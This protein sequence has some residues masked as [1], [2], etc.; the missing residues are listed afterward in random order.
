MSATL[1][2][3][4]VLVRE[5][6]CSIDSAQTPIIPPKDKGLGERMVV[7]PSLVNATLGRNWVMGICRQL[8]EKMKYRVVVLSPSES[9]ARE[10]QIFGAKVVIGDEVPVAVENL[11]DPTSEVR[12]VVFVQRYDGIDLPDDACRI[13][14]IDGL[15]QGESIVDKY[16]SSLSHIS[17]GTRNRLVYRIEQG[18]GRAVRSYADYAVVILAGSELAHFIAKHEILSAMNPEAAAQLRLAIDLAKLTAEENAMNPGKAVVGMIRQCLTRDEGWKRYYNES[19]RSV[20]KPVLGTTDQ[21][22]L[23]MANS[24][25][26]SFQS[27]LSNDP[28]KAAS[29]LR[30]AI[31]K[32]CKAEDPIVGWYLQRVAN[33]LY[34]SDPGESLQVQRSAYE[35]NSSMFCPPGV[36]KR[37]AQIQNNMVTMIQWFKEFQNPNGAIAAIEELRAKLSYNLSPAIIEQS[38]CDLAPLIGAE[39]S[40]PEN[41]SDEGPDD[42]W[43]WS[44]VAFVIEAKNKNKDTLHKDDAE[45]ITFSL[46]WFKKKYPA[47]KSPFPVVV[48][49][50]AIS[51]HHAPYPS[52]T[53]AFLPEGIQSLLNTLEQFYQALISKPLDYGT[54]KQV[55][56]LQRN[57]NLTPELIISEFTVAVRE[58]KE[59]ESS[60]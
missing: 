54:P 43:L 1:A 14:V 15:P 57:L 19:I 18:M 2:D 31:N 50:M 41:D 34:D 46:E 51:D 10:W 22:R 24:E 36:S 60:K 13:L 27:A 38:I 40:R 30:S 39:G 26:Q 3:D 49:K 44:D 52:G 9:K 23:F 47:R 45:Q 58:L 59:N 7:T 56:E 37:P 28:V 17:G 20:G 4:S 11:R 5:L 35:K 33:Y 32:Y 53:R 25:R 48:A 42:L 21:N 6:G 8:A 12:F 55:S 16:D 29:D